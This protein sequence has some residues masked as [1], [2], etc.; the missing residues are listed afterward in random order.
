LVK[1]RRRYLIDTSKT[2]SAMMNG[3][4]TRKQFREE[5]MKTTL[6]RLALVAVALAGVA[7]AQE[8]ITIGVNLELSGR[9]V[10]L[11]TPELEGIEAARAQMSEVLGRPV[12][13]SVC[14][15]ASTPEG[16]VA[17]A[18]RF[19]DEGVVGVLGTGGSTQAI[20]AAE[21]LQ[22][23]GIVMITPSSTNPATTQI[24]DYI[25][26]VAYNDEFQGEI[27]A[28]YL[29]NDEGARRVA[30]FRQQDDDYSFGLAGFFDE[31]FRA[32]GGETVVVDYTGGTVD[33]A[34]QL[35]DVR[36]FNPDAFYLPGFCP[37]LASLLPQLRQQGFAEQVLMGGDG[38]DDAQCPEGGGEV[39]NGF[40]FTAFAEPEQLTADPEVAERAEA[41]STFFAEN[42]PDGT[43]NGFTLAGADAYN[44]LVAA[45]EAA[46][47]TE[48][49]EV[50][51]AL[52]E[53]TDYPGVTGS[54]TFASTDGTPSNRILGFFEY[55][56]PGEDGEPWT[57]VSLEGLTQ[58]FGE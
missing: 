8:P 16:S 24:G 31:A 50:Q 52:A 45:I 22:E 37:E 57:K 32:L 30:V 58:T 53:L 54:I 38:T 10:S 5:T 55:Q 48:P 49:A 47:S 14:D 23:A 12:E 46:G 1:P 19:V 27:A 44:V 25:F 13:L 56:V 21:V 6:G 42:Q 34:A 51:A 4:Y 26:R 29:Y 43:F 35:N 2:T 28:N 18:N 3:L 40:L 33:F 9:L 17:C 20:P 15:N 39:F 11:G 36:A 7:S 41:F